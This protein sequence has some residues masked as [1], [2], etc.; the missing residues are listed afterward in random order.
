MIPGFPVEARNEYEAGGVIGGGSGGG[1]C[2]GGGRTVLSE[3][4]VKVPPKR[5]V[6]TGTDVFGEYA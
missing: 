5:F 2:A 1:L 3:G 6:V 4:F